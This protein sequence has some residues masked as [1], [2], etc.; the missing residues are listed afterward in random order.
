MKKSLII[1]L[2]LATALTLSW[3]YLFF[4]SIFEGAK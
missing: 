4:A 3:S 2:I 1:K